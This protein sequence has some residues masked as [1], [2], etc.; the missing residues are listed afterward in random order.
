MVPRAGRVRLWLRRLGGF[1]RRDR[2]AGIALSGATVV[3]MVWA[4]VAWSSYRDLWRAVPPLP[5]PLD[6]GFSLRNWVEQG[7]MTG[8]FA[9]V[10][11]EIRREIS[12]GELR[13]WRRASVP[14][15]AALAG[16]AVPAA[17]YAFV[18]AGS[19]GGRGW[20]I[21]MA[22]DV[23][24]AVGALALVVGGRP[25]LRVFLMTLAVADDIASVVLLVVFYNVGLDPVWVALGLAALGA[26]AAVESV[27]PAWGRIEMVLGC[28]AWW[29]LA[30]GGVEAA[31]VGVPIGALALPSRLSS[32]AVG[33]Q[34][35]RGWEER[36]TPWVNLG[37]LPL[38]ALADAGLH[39]ADVDFSSSGAL[40]VF[41]AI[42]LARVIG[43]PL[44]VATAA[45]ALRRIPSGH[46][47]ARI[48]RRDIVGIGVLA[49]MGFT[50]P[51]LIVHAALPAGPL[52]DSAI[53]GLLCATVVAAASGAVVLRQ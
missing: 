25:R 50:V 27:E 45:R 42:V 30:R 37:V 35:P 51:L 10:G 31:V 16:M 28:V 7:A 21:P 20:G 32:T 46:Y 44:G 38:F 5:G 14:I 53:L 9:L 15:A 13:S 36:I 8:F 19:L 23:A 52:A 12:A 47:D 1:G 6:L 39:L 26:M 29:A 34:G 3:A 22:T 17:I 33:R 2:A 48:D 43:K 18:V 41:T 4:N 24:F 49:G 11:L 40:R